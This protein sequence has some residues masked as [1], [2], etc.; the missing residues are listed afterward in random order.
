MEF[1]DKKQD[2]IDLQLTQFGRHLMSKGGFKPT[3][4]SFFDDNILYESEKAGL[5]EEQ[6]LSQER[7]RA[8]QTMQPQVSITSL[9]KNFKSTY[10][11]T[12]HETLDDKAKILNSMQKTAE[13]NYLLPMPLGTSGADT[14]D[15][16]SW[17]IKCLR[18]RMSGSAKTLQIGGAN[19]GKHILQ[20]PQIKI[21]KQI[22]FSSDANVGINPL[23]GEEVL[24]GVVTDEDVLVSSDDETFIF[25]K[26]LEQNGTFQKKN[27][28][29]EIF[30]IVEET[31][32]DV[33]TET[34]RPLS[35]TPKQ[36]SK[37]WI[38]EEAPPTM[39]KNYIGYY[40]DILSDEEIEE[41][42]LCQL[43]P[44]DTNRG[45]F[46]DDKQKKCVEVLGE[47]KLIVR[48]IYSDEEDYPGEIC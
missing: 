22:M 3:Y 16:P 45:V 47:D 9:D 30:E 8:S 37:P 10:E 32:N 20:I 28:D 12:H 42:I 25:L 33:K 13:K 6:N 24:S 2:V 17:N 46:A 27:F 19:G 11:V 39:D 31:E 4:Y 18:G 1:F 38:E 34:L 7:I 21:G 44:S 26:V 23:T 48:D 41:K 15:P 43:D 35:F 40:L 14:D 5:T 29:I 36:K